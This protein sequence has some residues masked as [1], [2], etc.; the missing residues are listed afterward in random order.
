MKTY[1]VKIKKVIFIEIIFSFL[2]SIVLAFIPY[3]QKLLFDRVFGFGIDILLTLAILYL[4]CVLLGVVFQYISQVYSWKTEVNF[5]LE[6]KKDLFHSISQYSYKKFSEKEIGEYLS[7]ANNDI[8]VL[9]SQYISGIV[10]IIKSIGMLIVSAVFVFVFVDYRIAIVIL[11]ASLVSVFV[12]KLLSKKLSSRRKVYQEQ[13]GLYFSSLKDFWE[14]FK[15]INAVTRK[16][17]NGRHQNI[18]KETEGKKLAFGKFK[19]LANIVNGFVMDFVNLSAFIAVGYLWYKNEITIG[20]AIATFG[21]LESFIYPIRYILNDINDINASKDTKIGVLELIQYQEE[22]DLPQLTEFNQNITIEKLSI[23]FENFNLKDFNYVFEKGKKYAIIGQSG[24][25]KSTLLNAIAKHNE[26]K[27]GSIYIDGHDIKSV[28]LSKICCYIDQNFHIFNDTF[29]HNVTTFNSYAFQMNNIKVGHAIRTK[30]ESMRKE[31]SMQSL[32]GGEKQ[33]LNMLHLLT[34]SACICLMDEPFSAMDAN[35]TYKMQQTFLESNDKTVIMA[36]HKI[37]QQSL[38]QFDE[39]IIMENG[40][41][42]ISGSYEEIRNS[43]A[44]VSLSKSA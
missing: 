12:P 17:I 22:I 5:N 18:L 23:D 15:R 26:A 9:G 4:S 1:I 19:T 21:Y 42:M 7:I 44:Y 25:G 36:T 10:D 2:Y 38:H 30:L 34:S 24:S 37:S 41:M 6:M 43:L 14:G 8:A 39:I 27:S 40:S 29:D 3:I 13:L 31:G 32:S 20:T 35:L 28:E 16:N 33:I 11:I